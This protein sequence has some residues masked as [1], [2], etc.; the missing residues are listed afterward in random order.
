MKK[1]LLG[2]FIAGAM[3]SSAHAQP[4]AVGEIAYPK[5]SVGYEALMLGENERAISQIKTN[6]Q[7]SRHD[8]AKLLNLGTA[9]ARTGRTNEAADVF[10]I[11]MQ[12]KDSVDLVLADGRVMNSKD[13]ARKAYAGLQQRIATR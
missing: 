11:A 6:A 9:Y 2:A 3:V 7:V 8:P 4:G 10:M 12:N 1:L 13:A 5:G